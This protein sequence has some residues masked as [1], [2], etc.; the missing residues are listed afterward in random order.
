MVD[1]QSSFLQQE[2]EQER[3]KKHQFIIIKE[4][5]LVLFPQEK[6]EL[7]S[8]FSCEIAGTTG[9]TFISKS[10]YS[11]YIIQNNKS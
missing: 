3:E 2:Q 1:F 5:S 8:T 7:S 9:K 4:K 10:Y 11:Y 6:V